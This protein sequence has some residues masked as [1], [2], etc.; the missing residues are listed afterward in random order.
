MGSARV[1]F[2]VAYRSTYLL[3]YIILLGLL[4]ITPGDAI[5]RSIKNK[6]NYNIWI[7][8]ISYV[9]TIGILCFIYALRLYVNKTVLDSIP[10]AW[11]PIEK[12]DLKKRVYKMITTGLNRS[13]AIAYESRPRSRQRKV[14]RSLSAAV[15]ALGLD[16]KSRKP[17]PRS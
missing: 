14:L 1:F 3:L 5:A 12:Q 15:A 6:Q 4:L 10:K 11:V 2:R 17:L 9:V 16:L 7:V 13:A 8:T